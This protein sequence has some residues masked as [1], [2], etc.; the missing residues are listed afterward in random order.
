MISGL[1][2]EHFIADKG[3]DSDSIVGQAEIQGMAGSHPSAKE[4]EKEQEDAT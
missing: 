3:Y 4:Q 1:K 2:A